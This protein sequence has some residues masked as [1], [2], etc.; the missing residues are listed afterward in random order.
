MTTFINIRIDGVERLEKRLGQIVARNVLNRSALA[1]AKHVK[2]KIAR[3]P[4]QA[5]PTNP[6]SWYQRG[7]GPRWRRADGTIGGKKTSENMGKQW[8]IDIDRA[9]SRATVGNKV[10]YVRWVQDKER[11]APIHEKNNWLTAQDMLEKNKS[12]IVQFYRDEIIK[13]WKRGI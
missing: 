1:A 3:Y 5:A 7:Y 10:T 2:G 13:A 12:R 11:Q 9:V 6:N 8:T 4:P